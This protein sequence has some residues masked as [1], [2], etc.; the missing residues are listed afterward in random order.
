VAGSEDAGFT[1]SGVLRDHADFAVLVLFQKDDPFGHLLFSDLPDGD[2]T[3]LVLDFD[4]RGRASN[5]GN[6]EECLDGLEHAGFLRE[7]MYVSSPVDGAALR[8][9][10]VG[11]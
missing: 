5:R 9:S 3:G 6:R 4:T 10:Q 11:R 1:V 2:L 8:A 7:L